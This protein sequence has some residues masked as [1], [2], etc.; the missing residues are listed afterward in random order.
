M[1][2][3]DLSISTRLSI[4]ALVPLAAV[5]AL[6]W[7][8]MID[9]YASYKASA[10]IAEA[11]HDI[12]L[13]SHVVQRLQVERGQTAGFLSSKGSA[14]RQELGSARAE[15]DKQILQLDEALV[16][17]AI[18]GVAPQAL[19]K[20]TDRLPGLSALRSGIDQL[21]T[22]PPQS[23]AFYT[24]LVGD[25]LDVTRTL[26][27]SGLDETV[28]A[29]LQAYVNLGLAKELAGQ[30]R[31]MGNG[32]I[33]SGRIP[34]DLYMNFAR[35]SG[36]GDI[37]IKEFAKLDPTLAATKLQSFA[38]SPEQAQIEEFRRKMLTAGGEASLA[39]LDARDWFGKTTARINI[40]YEAEL[41]ELAQIR[42]ASQAMA[43]KDARELLIAG[44][45]A[46]TSVGLTLFLGF[47][48]LMT[49]VRP[50]RAMVTVVEEHGR[51][52]AGAT[53]VVSQARDEIGRLGRAILLCM[54]NHARSA[55]DDA[56]ERQ[57]Q[58]EL[59]LRDTQ[60]H[61]MKEAERARAVEYAVHALGDGL[62]QLS[63]GNLTYQIADAFTG[64]LEPL[65]LAFNRSVVELKST[66]QGVSATVVTLTHGVSEL[67]AGANDLAER[68]QRQAASLEEASAALSEV[69]STLEE[70]SN[71]MRTVS[72]VTNGARKSA[73]TSAKITQETVGAMERIEASSGQIGQITEVIDGIAFQTNLLALNA[74][75]EAARAG[76]AGKGFAVV[77]QEVREL[78]Q[79]SAKAAKEIKQLIQASAQ[80]V[81]SGVELVQNSGRHM[82]EIRDHILTID[83]EISTITEGARQQ[84]TAIAEISSAVNNMD[85][86][87][88]RNAAMV[89]ESN[90]A[91]QAIEQE[92]QQLFDKISRFRLE[93]GAGRQDL[94]ARRVAA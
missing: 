94:R 66:M 69:T 20:V 21:T 59:R 81:Q 19:A 23:F 42:A 88:Q 53:M 10:R 68:T 28:G 34:P 55:R 89:E 1:R 13:I 18:L 70:T 24:G 47:L 32:F 26:S 74:G 25:L 71:R 3:S 14:N 60:A 64:D 11:S 16:N 62:T 49:V 77:A 9:E 54:E 58:A 30:E 15:T 36:A 83:R 5:V 92:G 2:F 33:T 72:G 78:A 82:V 63:A 76:E 61:R 91:T 6:A 29:R 31:G 93:D 41:A 22:T 79:R 40:L 48:T 43:A 57:R 12:E 73:E 65:R 45:I 39:G 44:A 75:V 17:A 90:A 27:L 87:T 7:H 51:G 84:S 8:L 4:C 50:L 37:L 80:A 46:A 38:A 56:E 86:M 35:Y 67:R 52:E 85:Q